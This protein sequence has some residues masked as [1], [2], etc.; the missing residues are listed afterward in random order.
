MDLRG[1]LPAVKLQQ[2]TKDKIPWNH[3]KAL[4]WTKGIILYTG[5]RHKGPLVHVSPIELL[6]GY[7]LY[8]W[9]QYA[10]QQGYE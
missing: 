2:N 8:R 4:P 5:W 6:V 10:S 9:E 3:G 1:G 7:R